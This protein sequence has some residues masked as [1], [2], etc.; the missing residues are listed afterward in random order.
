MLKGV[1]PDEYRG[2]PGKMGSRKDSRTLHMNPFSEPS[3]LPY[4][5][6]PFDQIRNEHYLPGFEQGMSEQRAQVQAI[7][8]DPAVPDFQNTILALE[9][10]GQMLQRVCAAFFNL[11]ASNTDPQMQ[12]IDSEIAPKL[13]A[14]EDAIYLNP[15]LLVRVDAVYQ[16]RGSLGL[17]SES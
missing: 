3:T 16:R 4:Q 10:A 12:E 14:H 7:A 17:D 11:N 15:A 2:G 13:Q 5:L 6:P 1:I 8:G 9:R